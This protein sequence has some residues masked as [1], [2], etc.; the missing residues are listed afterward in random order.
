VLGLTDALDDGVLDAAILE[1]RA[2]SPYVGLAADE[3]T[4]G[5]VPAIVRDL[6]A[7][8]RPAYPESGVA[9]GRDPPYHRP[10]PT[11]APPLVAFA[12]LMVILAIGAVAQRYVDPPL[13]WD[14]DFRRKLRNWDGLLP[15]WVQEEARSRRS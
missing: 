7:L 13:D 8:G 4:T 3:N 1:D 11:W 2:Q 10:V 14:D 6:P 15:V 12:V 5:H 9:G